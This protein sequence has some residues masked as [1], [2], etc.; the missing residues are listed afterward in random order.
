[1]ILRTFRRGTFWMWYR[2]DRDSKDIVGIFGRL[3]EMWWGEW[4][5]NSLKFHRRSSSLWYFRV[6]SCPL[7]CCSSSC[8]L[9]NAA[10]KSPSRSQ[11][12]FH[13]PSSKSTSAA[14]SHRRPTT[15]HML[16][17]FSDW[18]NGISV[19]C[20]RVFTC[21]RQIIYFI[22]NCN[23]NTCVWRDYKEVLRRL[24]AGN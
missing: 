10:R 15:R 13:S 2:R 17:G 23:A 11:F 6:S 8:C 24:P 1:M 20:I 14:A 22:L 4:K 5:K 18:F 19:I 16:V 12:S 7:W 21:S 9:R 3:A